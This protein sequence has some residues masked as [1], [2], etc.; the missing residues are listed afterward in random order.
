MRVQKLIETVRDEHRLRV[1]RLQERQQSVC[2]KG[3]HIPRLL[4]AIF[5]LD[6]ASI[7]LTA[8]ATPSACGRVVVV[9]VG[10]GVLS[11]F[12]PITSASQSRSAGR[13]LTLAITYKKLAEFM[14]F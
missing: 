4:S 7:A 1:V 14:V 6:A 3:E 13:S 8:L 12:S 10:D 11:P 9:S 5:C 2:G